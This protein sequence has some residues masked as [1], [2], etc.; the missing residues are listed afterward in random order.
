MKKAEDKVEIYLEL[1]I[2]NHWLSS[3]LGKMIITHFWNCPLCSIGWSWKDVQRSVFTQSGFS[4]THKIGNIGIISHKL[5][6][7]FLFVPNDV[8]KCKIRYLWAP[9]DYILGLQT[10]LGVV[11]F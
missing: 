7:P 3:W 6:F 5:Q 2:L 4:Q 10:S 1:T 11:N 9:E 8:G